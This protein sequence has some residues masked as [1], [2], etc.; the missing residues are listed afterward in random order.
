MDGTI[1]AWA[2]EQLSAYPVRLTDRLIEW[3]ERAPDRTFLAER[4]P[5]GEWRTLTYAEALRQV[6]SVAQWLLERE[7]DRARPVAIFL[8]NSIDHAL[9]ALGCLYAGVPYAPVGK[10][11]RRLVLPWR[12]ALLFTD[13]S[14]WPD[15]LD[16]STEVVPAA[17]VQAVA[18]T[19]VSTAV[20]RTHQ[21][22]TAD[23]V[24]KILFTSGSSGEPKGIVTTQ[25]ILCANAEMLRWALARWVG[26]TPPVVCDWLPWNHVYGGSHNFGFVLY[27][28]GTLFIDQG[29]PTTNGFAQTLSN[30]QEVAPTVYFNVPRGFQ[31]LVEALRGDEELRRK[32]FSRSPVLFSAAAGM[33]Q[34]VWDELRAMA[35]ATVGRA[36]PT[37]TGF[38]A[39]ETGPLALFT[40]D[41]TGVA[42]EVGL[43]VPGVE[44]KLVPHAGE[45]LE[46][47]LRGPN[48]MAG[49]WAAG[50][51]AT[52]FDGE[53]FFSSGDLLEFADENEP[54]RGLRFLGRISEDFKLSTGVWVRVEPLR[55]RILEELGEWVEEVILAG[56]GRDEVGAILFL[57]PGAAGYLPRT[58]LETLEARACA[59]ENKI[60]RIL[61][62]EHDPTDNVRSAKASTRMTLASPPASLVEV[63]YSGTAQRMSQD[64]S[65]ES[66]GGLEQMI[67]PKLEIPGHNWEE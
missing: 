2:T 22:V 41:G 23:T 40:G 55:R 11:D 4:G 12:P 64:C 52:G 60:R 15:G 56:P 59:S 62:V 38:G 10:R 29:R 46:L 42:G 34:S 39:T 25:R 27:H 51:S 26:D 24:A 48:V 19:P 28:G 14:D 45:S 3:A 47:R 32:F 54:L 6:R 66:G 58:A 1:Y 44:L 5:E 63:L 31:M 36:V 17:E 21:A 18:K 8:P 53:G 30:L 61:L 35:V 67:C 7:P 57:R 65:I 16:G 33:R 50:E 9:L 49:Y 43:P 13:D 37:V 20:E